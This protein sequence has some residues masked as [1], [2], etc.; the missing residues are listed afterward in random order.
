MCEKLQVEGAPHTQ[1]TCWICGEVEGYWHWYH[2]ATLHALNESSEHDMEQNKLWILFPLSIR[3][4]HTFIYL[5]GGS[6]CW[7]SVT[8]FCPF[9]IPIIKNE[10][11]YSL[12]LAWLVFDRWIVPID[13]VRYSYIHIGILG[14]IEIHLFRPSSE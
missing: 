2:P 11:L 14:M 7:T 10:I 9:Q 3:R 1:G 8:S 6:T 13:I 4:G 5:L 12:C